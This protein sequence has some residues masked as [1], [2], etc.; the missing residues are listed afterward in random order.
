MQSKYSVRNTDIQ[1]KEY[2]TQCRNTGIQCCKSERSGRD[3]VNPWIQAANDMRKKKAY[4]RVKTGLRSL[5]YLGV[6]RNIHHTLDPFDTILLEH[7]SNLFPFNKIMFLCSILS[8]ECCTHFFFWGE[9]FRLSCSSQLAFSNP[10]PNRVFY[11][12]FYLAPSS[13]SIQFI[14][15]ATSIWDAF[16]VFEENCPTFP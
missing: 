4:Q 5:V 8:E 7:I 15:L 13:D 1:C 10:P 6:A 12:Y 3:R 2:G 14:P 11:L 16:F 9:M